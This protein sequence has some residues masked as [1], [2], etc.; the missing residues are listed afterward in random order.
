MSHYRIFL[1]TESDY[2]QEEYTNITNMSESEIE[3]DEYEIEEED[4][5]EIEV[6]YDYEYADMPRLIHEDRIGFDTDYEEN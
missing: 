3:E 2:K 5:Y 4:E 6:E 1:I